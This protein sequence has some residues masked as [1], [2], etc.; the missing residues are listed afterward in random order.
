[1]KVTFRAEIACVGLPTL[2]KLSSTMS[3]L[4]EMEDIKLFQYSGFDL[5]L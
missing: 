5:E 3:E 2:L 4:L 1:M